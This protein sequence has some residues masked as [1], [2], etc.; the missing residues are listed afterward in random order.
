MSC[1]QPASGLQPITKPTQVNRLKSG[2]TK[3]KNSPL[4]ISLGVSYSQKLSSSLPRP[5]SPALSTMDEEFAMPVNQ[6]DGDGDQLPNKHSAQSKKTKQ[7]RTWVEILPSLVKPYIHLLNE[8]NG[9]CDS[10][11]PTYSRCCGC[12]N[13]YPKRCYLI[14]QSRMFDSNILFNFL[15]F[16]RNYSQDIS[17]LLMHQRLRPS[18]HL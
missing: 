15:T 18:T 13:L 7:W 8:S 17:Y 11:C 16:S 6:H 2:V 9:L 14:L 3:I 12:T 4:V 1:S 5:P 10:N